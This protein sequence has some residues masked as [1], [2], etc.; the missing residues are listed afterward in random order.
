MWVA[1]FAR[2]FFNLTIF[3]YCVYFL[4]SLVNLL[5]HLL[6]ILLSIKFTLLIFQN[7]PRIRLINLRP[8]LFCRNPRHNLTALS[9][10]S[11]L[12]PL[13]YHIIL[14]NHIFIRFLYGQTSILINLH[15]LIYK[16]IFIVY[17][18]NCITLRSFD[19][20][21][22]E[23]FEIWALWESYDVRISEHGDGY[24]FIYIETNSRHR[25]F[26]FFWIYFYIFKTYTELGYV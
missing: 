9:N 11:L 3:T 4:L 22:S 21:M 13:I 16:W 20:Y 19:V 2:I 8:R 5:F 15:I 6:L 12:F 18:T 17:G 23:G 14:I 25:I 24:I 26:R 7:P 10:S 1:N